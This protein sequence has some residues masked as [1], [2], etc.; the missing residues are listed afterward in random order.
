MIAVLGVSIL[1]IMGNSVDD[2]PLNA[3][4]GTTASLQE[5][6][7][8]VGKYD[9]ID[10]FEVEGYENRKSCDWVSRRR[11]A[12]RCSLPMVN[13]YCPITCGLCPTV[14][15]PSP[16][17]VDSGVINNGPEPISS[18]YY[19]DKD[20]HTANSNNEKYGFLTIVVSTILG[21]FALMIGVIALLMWKRKRFGNLRSITG[22]DSFSFPNDQT[23]T[24]KIDDTNP[25]K[26]DSRQEPLNSENVHNETAT[27]SLHSCSM[28]CGNLN[29]EQDHISID[30]HNHSSLTFTSDDYENDTV[31]EYHQ[32]STFS[33]K[34]T[35]WSRRIERDNSYDT[36]SKISVLS[37]FVLPTVYDTRYH[38]GENGTAFSNTQSFPC[39][40]EE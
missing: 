9:T 21:G 35:V 16:S 22:D 25:F 31:S 29:E 14:F 38:S 34:T 17:P 1:P 23:S 37:D 11:T 33:G 30:I 2:I 4:R 13:N 36:E 3:L 20:S 5:Q 12:E 32:S 6:Y 24:I 15:E 18:N 10:K 7:I 27:G 26:K 19:G 28:S 8:C 39:I 40:I